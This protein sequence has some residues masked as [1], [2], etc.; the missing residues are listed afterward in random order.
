MIFIEDRLAALLPGETHIGPQT[1]PNSIHSSASRM[2]SSFSATKSTTMKEH[3]T[4]H[5]EATPEAAARAQ[6]ASAAACRDERPSD[7]FD[8]DAAVASFKRMIADVY[9]EPGDDE[10]QHD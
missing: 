2:K 5:L 8:W 10:P 9:D 1:S 4:A 6:A 3:E 7:G